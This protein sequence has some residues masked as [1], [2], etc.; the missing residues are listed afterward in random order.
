MEYVILI[1]ASLGLTN[2]VTREFVFE[3][4][5]K[6]VS[7]INPEGPLEKLFSCETCMGF[8]VGLMLA[9]FAPAFTGMMLFDCFLYGLAS[10][11]LNKLV[12]G[13]LY[14]R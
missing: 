4:L 6:L 5:R 14:T 2:A 9:P 11:A 10:S 12:W 13:W 8:W 3:W 7:R 1:L